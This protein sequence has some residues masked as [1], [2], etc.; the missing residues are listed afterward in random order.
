MKKDKADEW[1]NVRWRGRWLKPYPA[2]FKHQINQARAI[3]RAVVY[4]VNLF[5]SNT[6]KVPRNGAGLRRDLPTNP[7]R[8]AV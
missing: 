2:E 7:N 8:H 3:A 1:Y 4:L 5:G 6:P